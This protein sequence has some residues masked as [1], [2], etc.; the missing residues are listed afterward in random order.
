MHF[1]TRLLVVLAGLLLGPRAVIADELAADTNMIERLTPEQARK[2]VAKFQHQSPSLN[3][4]GLTTLDADTV[5]ALVEFKGQ[6]LSLY[7][8]TTRA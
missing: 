3:L 6:W 2:L 5:K 1:L 4:D 8:L 7:G